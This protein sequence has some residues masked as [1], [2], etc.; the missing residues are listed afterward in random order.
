MEPDHFSYRRGNLELRSCDVHLMQ[1]GIHTCAE[2]VIWAPNEGGEFC[3]TVA[4]FKPTRADP[5]NL[6]SVGDRM[7]AAGVD[8]DVMSNMIKSYYKIHEVHM[9]LRT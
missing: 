9:L 5:P 4:Y 7:V 3:C 2:I 8:W 1:K 6:I